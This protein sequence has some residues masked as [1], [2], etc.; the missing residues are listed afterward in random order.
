MFVTYSIIHESC[1]LLAMAARHVATPELLDPNI[2]S[3]HRSYLSAVQRVQLTVLRPRPP[4][5][6]LWLDQHWFGR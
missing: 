1:H 2:D 5:E 6:L 4:R 3:G